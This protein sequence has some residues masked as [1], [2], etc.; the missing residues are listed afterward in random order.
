VTERPEGRWIVEG[1]PDSFLAADQDIPQLAG[2]LG[3]P[4]R[5]VRQT[6]HGFALWTGKDFQPLDEGQAA[7]LLGIQARKEDLAAGHSS[8]AGGMGE[9]VEAL[10]NVVGSAIRYRVGVTGAQ[11]ATAGFRLSGTG[12]QLI[13]CDAL[14]I[15]LPA[16]AA[17]RLFTG[18]DLDIRHTLTAVRYDPSLT[19]SLAYEAKQ[20][21]GPLQG[22]G[23]VVS[24]EAGTPVRACTYASSKFPGRAPAGHVLLRVFLA[25]VA[26][27]PAVVGHEVLAA[28]LGISGAPLWTKTYSWRLG[29]RRPT[30]HHA[31]EVARMRAR[32]E[33]V[34]PIALAGG[35]FEGPGV[36][37]CVRSGREA[38]KEVLTV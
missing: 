37:G 18:V 29:L 17:A 25:P 32:L 24:P 21:A 5:L 16:Y 2:E 26:G 23:F 28:M 3:I 11:H 4:D 36:S 34:G 12:G 7:A 31:A 8:F 35:G 33:W 6:G 1:G 20:L 15:A 30:P 19:V 38:A 22:T 27:D 14:V 10:V 13:H 9:L